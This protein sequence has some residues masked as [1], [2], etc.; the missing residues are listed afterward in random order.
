V[1]WKSA[2]H[3][4]EDLLFFGFTKKGDRVFKHSYSFCSLAAFFV[5]LC[6]SAFP[7]N[8]GSFPACSTQKVNGDCTFVI[9]RL[10]PVTMPAIQVRSNG[11]VE[12]IV[13]NALPFERLALNPQSSQAIAGTDQ[14]AGFLTSAFPNL[15]GLVVVSQSLGLTAGDLTIA[16]SDPPEVQKVKADL[17][18]LNKML[19]I[20]DIQQQIDSFSSDASQLN[21]QIQQVFLPLP[22]PVSGPAINPCEPGNTNVG[23]PSPWQNYACWRRVVICQLT[24]T[25]AGIAPAPPITNVLRKGYSLVCRLPGAPTGT[26]AS[27]FDDDGFGKQAKQ[28]AAD[29]AQLAPPDQAQFVD[30][31]SDLQ[32][33]RNR[34]AAVNGPLSTAVKDLSTY[35][36]NIQQVPGD[37]VSAN[38]S[39]LGQITDPKHSASP[40]SASTK[41]LGRQVVFAVEATNQIAAFGDSVSAAAQRKAIITVTVLFADPIFEASAGVFF[42]SL[43]NRSFSNQTVVIQNPGAVPTPGNIVITRT[44]TRP[45]LLPFVAGNWRIGHDFLVGQRRS[46]IYLTAAVAFNPYNTLPEFAVGPSLSWRAVMFSLLYHE[47]HDVRLTQGEFVGEVWCNA[48]AANG[49]IPKCS[50]SPPA[51]STERFWTGAVALGVSVRVPTIFG[52]GK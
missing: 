18:S 36:V 13:V 4:H 19:E 10:Y 27:Q 48:T 30:T 8:I 26:C 14:I 11:R 45:T 33:R 35:L 37:P 40:Q 44:I 39:V 50:G 41:L 3:W 42:S 20:P 22:R 49:Q 15:K 7:Q 32:Q 16:P 52:G 38:G 2:G 17:L 47:G 5:L 1:L 28:T 29:I 24:G 31:L 51:P 21:L 25:C 34:L 46:A 9:D 43:P 12:V 6:H 23:M